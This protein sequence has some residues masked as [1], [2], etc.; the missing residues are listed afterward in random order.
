MLSNTLH[1]E[2]CNFCQEAPAEGKITGYLEGEEYPVKLDACAKCAK[3]AFDS[4]D[5]LTLY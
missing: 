1:L 5:Q 4:Q 2:W 3:E